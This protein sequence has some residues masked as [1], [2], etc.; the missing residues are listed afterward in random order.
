[1]FSKLKFL[2][3][4]VILGF[5]PLVWSEENKTNWYSAE[6]SVGN[7]VGIG[8]FFSGYARSPQWTTSFSIG[9]AIDLPLPESWPKVSL[10]GE[11]S[12]NVWWL[13]SLETSSFDSANRIQFADLAFNL[14]VPKLFEIPDAGITFSAS[15]P[16]IAPIS[17][18]SRAFSRVLSL[19]ASIGAAYKHKFFAVSFRPEARAWIHSGQTKTVP[20]YDLQGDRD[21]EAT[22]LNPQNVD[23][24]V[25]QYMMALSLYREDDGSDGS[26]C[27]VSG[28]QSMGTLKLPLSAGLTFESHKIALGL[29]FYWNFLRALEYRPE[30]SSPNSSSHAFTE[31]VA[32]KVAYT[33]VLP[34]TFDLAV[35][36]GVISYQ[37]LFSKTGTLLFPFFD[38]VTPLKNQTHIFLEMTASL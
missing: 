31:A 26:S 13:N 37:S 24:E 28:R 35:T 36:T 27:V 32:G 12:A 25:D 34:T 33:Y 29:S 18:S 14:S 21:F 16:V 17:K 8:T 3:L 7:S 38:F 15:L 2:I 10:D 5:T 30:L 9:S 22:I 4:P 23:F 1:M 19:G 11:V 6:F 20:C